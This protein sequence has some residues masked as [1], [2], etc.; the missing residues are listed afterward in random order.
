MSRTTTAT[1]NHQLTAYAQGH[2]NDLGSAMELAERLAPTVPVPGGSGQYKNFD[3]LNSFQTHN[4]S[5]AMG[6]DAARMEF[7]ATDAYYNTKPQALEVTVDMEERE[8]AG[9]DN[10]LGQQLLDEGKVRA[11]LNVTSLGHVRK[12]SEYVVAQL[13]AVADRGNWS[14]TT[15]DPIDQIDEQLDLISKAVGST[16]FL[17]VTMDI[18]AWRTIRT[19]PKVKARVTGAQATPLTRQQLVDSLAIPVDLGIYGIAYNAA[20]LGQTSSKARVLASNVI[21]HYGMPN[22]T[23]YDPSAFKVFTMDRSKITS[24][25]TWQHPS[26]RYDVHAIDW[27]EDIKKTSS[28]AAVRLA[29]T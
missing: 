11:L 7:K 27:S 16:N 17:K 4:T 2:M 28:I 24:V 29:I 15:I 25:R 3:D 21:I 13:T 1:L 9:I 19:H 12:V 22:P 20:A 14:N 6:G 23:Q 18:T 10:P 26:G 8:K 5:R